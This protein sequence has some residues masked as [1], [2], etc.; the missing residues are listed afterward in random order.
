[1]SVSK[2]YEMEGSYIAKYHISSF[3]YHTLYCFFTKLQVH[4]RQY[5]QMI[6]ATGS[7][8]RTRQV[9]NVRGRGSDKLPP[10]LSSKIGIEGT[11]TCQQPNKGPRAFPARS[12][13]WLFYALCKSFSGQQVACNLNCSWPVWSL[14]NSKSHTVPEGKIVGTTLD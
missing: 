8:L 12:C 9:H 10:C 11:S 13:L 3:I 1:M 14:P 6:L 4:A 2:I 5:D 7:S